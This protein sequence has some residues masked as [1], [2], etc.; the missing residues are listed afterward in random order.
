MSE[1]RI[2]NIVMENAHIIFKNFSGKEGKYNPPGRRNFCVI[3]DEDLSKKLMMDGWNIKYLR[4]R[5]DDDQPTPYI[6]VTVSYDYNPPKVYVVTSK[7]KTLLD[8][9][10][11]GMIDWAETNNIDLVIRPYAWEVNGKTGVKAYLKTMY[12]T[13]LEDDLDRKYNSIDERHDS[14]VMPP[15]TEEETAPF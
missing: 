7:G 14:F 11:V 10:E 4:P 8:E 5:D 6:P 9:D 1:K 13:I 2:G 3:L 12:A 15:N